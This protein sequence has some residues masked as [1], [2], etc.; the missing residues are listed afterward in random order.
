MSALICRK[1]VKVGSGASAHWD[2]DTSVRGPAAMLTGD[3][4]IEQSVA[5][6]LQLVLGEWFLDVSRGI[7]WFQ[8]PNASART[9]LGQF[10]A[11]LA[12]AESLIKAAVL[13]VPGVNSITFF[14][15]A[16]DHATR[17]AIPTIR[18]TT[19]NGGTFAVSESVP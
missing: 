2:V 8:Q 19:V 15:F 10:P 6:E 4:A 1:L 17:S 5:C 9:I 3:A 12:Y 14:S 11:D 16:F 18:G 13:R 7:P